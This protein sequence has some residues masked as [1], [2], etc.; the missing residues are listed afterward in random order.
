MLIGVSRGEWL[1][2]QIFV[3]YTVSY[4]ETIWEYRFACF[5]VYKTKRVHKIIVVHLQNR[6]KRLPNREKHSFYA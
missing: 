1:H 6:L 5:D 3:V 2:N 4:P